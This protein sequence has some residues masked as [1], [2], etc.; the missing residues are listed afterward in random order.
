VLEIVYTVILVA[1]F[2]A[3]AGLAIYAVRKLYSGQR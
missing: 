3:I 1:A 2:L